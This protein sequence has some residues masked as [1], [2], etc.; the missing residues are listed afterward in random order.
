MYNFDTINSSILI[1][2][3]VFKPNLTS[4]L[5]FDVACKKIKNGS[6]VL[7]LGCGSGIIG[8]GI[9]KNKKKIKLYCSD[10]SESACKLT[11][12]NIKKNNLTANTK[13]GDLFLPWK[14]MKFDYIINDVSGISNM[15]AKKSPWFNDFVPC[16]SGK[17]GAKLTI[18]IISQAKKYLNPKGIL[19]LPII[20]LSNEKKILKKAKK[21]F[22][23][24]RIIE[25]ADWFLPSEMQ[26]LHKYLENLKS[27]GYINFIK[28]FGRIICTTSIITC[29]IIKK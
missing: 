26:N 20:S 23:N 6:E 28:K 21:I 7:D 3:K 13:N 25:K 17:D 10:S 18:K 4:K 5:S 14:N 29:T 16:D 1:N 27:K 24:V 12:R 8:I 2:K 15:V 9:L 22:K 11:I 19:Q